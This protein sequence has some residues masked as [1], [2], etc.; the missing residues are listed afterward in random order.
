MPHVKNAQIISQTQLSDCFKLFDGLS[1]FYSVSNKSRNIK[2][3]NPH[4]CKYLTGGCFFFHP[5]RSFSHEFH[6]E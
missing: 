3:R 1:R 2:Y 6:S 5:T 4:E